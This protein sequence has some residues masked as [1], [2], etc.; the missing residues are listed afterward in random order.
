MPKSIS[1]PGA[2]A[3]ITLADKAGIHLQQTR[4]VSKTVRV[5]AADNRQVIRTAAQVR[6]EIRNFQFGLAVAEKLT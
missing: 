2:K 3:R 6:K 5:A 4:A 1:H